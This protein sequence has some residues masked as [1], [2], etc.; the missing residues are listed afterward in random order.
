MTR[1]H[2]QKIAN[3]LGL[4]TDDLHRKMGDHA[5]G[6]FWNV[7]HWIVTNVCCPNN[8]AELFGDGLKGE[9]IDTI[10]ECLDHIAWHLDD[11]NITDVLTR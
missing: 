4:S 7:T 10:E 9:K 5:D 1:K 6:N 3:L 11:D 8:D 2:L